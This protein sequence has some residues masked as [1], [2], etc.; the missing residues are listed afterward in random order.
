MLEESIEYTHIRREGPLPRFG[1]YLG[2]G[3]AEGGATWGPVPNYSIFE[4]YE[5]Q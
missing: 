5:I 1:H 4:T 3:S 2:Y